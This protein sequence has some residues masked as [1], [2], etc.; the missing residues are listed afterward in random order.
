[1]VT[2][3]GT[4]INCSINWQWLQY[5]GLIVGGNKV[6]LIFYRILP[7]VCLVV[8]RKIAKC[9][10]ITSPWAEI[11]IQ[12]LRSTKVDSSS[13]HL[14]IRSLMTTVSVI[15]RT[16]SVNN[17]R[18]RRTTILFANLVTSRE[19]CTKQRGFQVEIRLTRLIRHVTYKGPAWHLTALNQYHKPLNTAA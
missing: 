8:T 11:W 13:L 7:S 14:D 10:R 17:S 19:T 3:G 6:V 2:D 12:D 4:V 18:L 5:A 9:L 15:G 1:M 16:L